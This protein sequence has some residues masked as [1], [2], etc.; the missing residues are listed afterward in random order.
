MH[1]KPATIGSD[2]HS[3][4]QTLNLRRKWMLE[5]DEIYNDRSHTHLALE[6]LSNLNEHDANTEE[7]TLSHCEPPSII[8]SRNS[9][10]FT[11]ISFFL[12]L[13]KGSPD[14]PI[15]SE[16]LS[17]YYGQAAEETARTQAESLQINL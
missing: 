5:R 7:D 3:T 11:P 14:T 9:L 1:S 6:H 10:N 15:D 4:S 17:N 16:D 13:G 2:P 12:D 8:Q